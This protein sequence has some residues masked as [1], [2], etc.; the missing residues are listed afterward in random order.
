[1]AQAG[2][3][4]GIKKLIHVRYNV[5]YLDDGCTEISEFTAI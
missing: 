5:Q 4:T 2:A 3:G 1:M